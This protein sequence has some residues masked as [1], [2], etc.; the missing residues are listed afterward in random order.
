MN[1]LPAFFQ[2]YATG[3]S[4]ALNRFLATGVGMTGLAGTVAFDSIGGLSHFRWQQNGVG[5]LR[6]ACG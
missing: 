5:R 3:D 4:A 2:A 6:K 1:E